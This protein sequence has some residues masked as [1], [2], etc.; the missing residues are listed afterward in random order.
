[1]VDISVCNEGT[2]QPEVTLRIEPH[3]DIDAF[4]G[5][6]CD[7]EY[8]D[9]VAMIDGACICFRACM[10]KTD[11]D[12][13]LA[14][15]FNH[16]D[17]LQDSNDDNVL[18]IYDKNGNHGPITDRHFVDKSDPAAGTGTCLR[19]VQSANIADGQ[20]WTEVL[21]YKISFV[22]GSGARR[23][24]SVSSL[25]IPVGDRKLLSEHGSGGRREIRGRSREE[26]R[27]SCRIGDEFTWNACPEGGDRDWEEDEERNWT[28]THG[29]GDDDDDSG[30]TGGG[31]DDD[32]VPD[33]DPPRN[34]TRPRNRT[35]HE[36]RRGRRGD[37]DDDDERRGRRRG[38]R[39]DDDD[40]DNDDDDDGGDGR[41]LLSARGSSHRERAGGHFGKRETRKC[42][43]GERRSGFCRDRDEFEG[44]EVMKALGV[45]FFICVVLFIC[46]G[47][48]VY[49]GPKGIST[50]VVDV[51]LPGG[52]PYAE[53]GSWPPEVVGVG[54]RDEAKDV[55]RRART[56]ERG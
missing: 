13:G 3:V 36:R 27:T 23:L 55:R 33:V 14:I 41:R 21:Y 47:V 53:T 43:N 6:E 56:G 25:E 26:V 16:V 5:E 49:F 4:V 46:G 52:I 11:Q 1:V 44:S 34:H 9:E 20:E 45:L 51:G 39:D 50:P 15:D 10:E 29:G 19:W 7:V 22:D 35:H 38:R 54:E 48:C 17:I 30:S 28:R 18:V 40:A 2:S 8:S 31:D 12:D 32:D 42:S 24:L 37:D